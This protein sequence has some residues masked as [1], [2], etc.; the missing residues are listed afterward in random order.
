MTADHRL[1][2]PSVPSERI[3]QVEESRSVVNEHT[4]S[5]FS[6]ERR[7]RETGTHT[8]LGLPIYPAHP[9]R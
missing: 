8:V 1:Q 4:E 3:N 7:S 6:R 9:W 2:G 5:L